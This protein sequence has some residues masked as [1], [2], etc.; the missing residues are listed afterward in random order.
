[1]LPRQ[2]WPLAQGLCGDLD[3][4]VTVGSWPACAITGASLAKGEPT[5]PSLRLLL[6]PV[7]SLFS[8]LS[9]SGPM[10]G[11]HLPAWKGLPSAL[12]PSSPHGFFPCSEDDQMVQEG[13]PLLAPPPGCARGWMCHTAVHTEDCGRIKHEGAGAGAGRGQGCVSGVPSA[14]VK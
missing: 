9:L 1:M 4:N 10:G 12:P 7:L 3:L 8:V 6:G 2:A 13:L 5:G 14:R 11:I